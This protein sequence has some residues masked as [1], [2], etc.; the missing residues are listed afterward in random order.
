MS[1]DDVS[2]VS[3]R[4][5]KVTKEFEL[6][7][8]RYESHRV[9]LEQLITDSP[10]ETLAGRYADVMMEVDSAI[11]KLEELQNPP[12]NRPA[13]HPGGAVLPGVALP[14]TKPSLTPPSSAGSKPLHR[15]VSDHGSAQAARPGSNPDRPR[16]LSIVLVGVV[17]LAVLGWLAWTLLGKMGGADKATVASTETVT[18]STASSSAVATETAESTLTIDP[19]TA[20][21]GVVKKGT[22]VAKSFTVRNNGDAPLT[23]DIS[24]STCR[25]IWFDMDGPVP[26]QST[27][28]LGVIVD[29]ARTKAGKL[30]ETITIRAKEQPDLETTLTVSAEVRAQ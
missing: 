15:P 6:L 21:Y 14:V 23:L 26:P 5:E 2:T 8:A 18:D 27:R 12:A 10:T 25:C 13:T 11:R 19:E 7:K 20:D 24:R 22:R 17:V 1:D 28:Q 3:Y 9:T 30:E 16:L 4:K 29:G